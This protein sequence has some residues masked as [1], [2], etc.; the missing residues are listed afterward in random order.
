[1]GRLTSGLPAKTDGQKLG[2]YCATH[3]NGSIITAA[4]DE[5]GRP[6]HCKFFDFRICFRK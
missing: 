1:V 2:E 3:P 4:E 5:M 6:A